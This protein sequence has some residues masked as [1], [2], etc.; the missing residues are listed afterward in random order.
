VFVHPIDTIKTRLQA[1]R[2]AARAHARA[3]TRLPA[4]ATH[5][6]KTRRTSSHWRAPLHRPPRSPLLKRAYLRRRP[7]EPGA[8]RQVSEPPKKLRKWRKK[9]A[10]AKNQI[11]VP[12]GSHGRTLTVP[13]WAYKGPGDI[14][15]GLTGAIVGTLPTALVYF[16][17]YDRVSAA[18]EAHHEEAD[19]ARGGAAAA[20]EHA[21]G[22]GRAA[23]VHLLSAAAGAVAS[24]FV[25]VP[26]DT[27]RHQTQAY[28]HNSFF[29][30]ARTIV[31]R[32][33]VRGLYLGY[34]P[35]LLRDVPE[36][37]VQFTAYE[38]LRR[39]AQR[40]RT[41]AGANPKLATWE[42]LVLGGLAGA[43]A[44][45]VTMVRARAALQ[46]ALLCACL[47]AL[48]LL[49]ACA[50][51]HGAD[52]C[53]S[54]SRTRARRC[55]PPSRWTSSRRGS[56]AAPWAAWRRSCAASSRR[57]ACVA[58]SPASA[59]ACATWRPPAPCSLACSRAPS[60]C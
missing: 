35:T 1:R 23:S 20:A 58:S 34:L 17:V 31:T 52:G 9:L 59:R 41:D 7:A 53:A 3:T 28:L 5:G 29:S 37:A 4:I 33:G 30:A 48:C 25:R 32:D 51:P 49:C 46:P 54:L 12:V 43:A 57:R 22:G 8:R 60:C 2:G 10:K 36:L 56:S 39:A 21:S 44:A 40:R 19:A 18:L 47:P 14:Y 6:G 24:S 50:P 11:I 15:R 13:N 42:H 55:H 26:G 16:T 27:C 45:T 38:A